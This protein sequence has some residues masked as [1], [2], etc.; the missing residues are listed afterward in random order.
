MKL[1]PC[2][3][4]GLFGLATATAVLEMQ[5]FYGGESFL[6]ILGDVLVK[7]LFAISAGEDSLPDLQYPTLWLYSNFLP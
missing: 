7:N 2:N 3:I 5:D 6:G 4:V 1:S